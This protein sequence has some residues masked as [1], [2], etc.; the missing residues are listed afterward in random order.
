MHPED[1]RVFVVP[2][3]TEMTEDSMRDYIEGVRNGSIKGKPKVRTLLQSSLSR[4]HRRRYCSWSVVSPQRSR[5]TT[6]GLS[7]SWWEPLSMIW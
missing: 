4:R 6:M 1:E 5:K 3:E 7:R 2:E